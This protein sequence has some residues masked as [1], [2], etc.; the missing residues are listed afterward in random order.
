MTK[1][2]IL[3]LKCKRYVNG[4][5]FVAVY[6]TGDETTLRVWVAFGSEGLRL[7]GLQRCRLERVIGT[8]CSEELL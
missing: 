8:C 4:D 7:M 5:R 1:R 6:M 3:G 2:E